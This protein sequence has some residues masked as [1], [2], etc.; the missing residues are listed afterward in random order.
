MLP[1]QFSLCI[2]TGTHLD[3]GTSLALACSK[4]VLLASVAQAGLKCTT[5][6]FLSLL[7]AP[8]AVLGLHYFLPP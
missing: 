7:T 6:L 4:Q 3:T 1:R 5:I 8:T 2:T